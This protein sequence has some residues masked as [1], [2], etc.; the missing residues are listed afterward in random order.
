MIDEGR[1]AMWSHHGPPAAPAVQRDRQVGLVPF[2][3]GPRAVSSYASVRGYF[4]S[5][6]SESPQACWLWITYL[7]GQPE[8]AQGLPARRSVAE[9]EAYRQG[10]GDERAAAYL[11]GMAGDE[12]PWLRFSD[13]GWLWGASYWLFRAYGQVLAGE[14]DVEEALDAAQKMA[15]GYRACVIAREAFFDQAQWQA[16]LKETD[17]ALPQFLFGPD[18]QE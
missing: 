7:T 14:A 4:I 17:P 1:A 10:V 6:R 12:S 13:D 16:C 8:A 5:A 11:A 2:P 3:A 9:S 15:D 18:R